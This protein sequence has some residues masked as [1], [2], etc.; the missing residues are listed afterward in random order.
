MYSRIFYQKKTKKNELPT[1]VRIRLEIR[2]ACVGPDETTRPIRV[3]EY[4]GF[5]KFVGF[6]FFAFLSNLLAESAES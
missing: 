3:L 2:T 1:I 6:F 5:L 4:S